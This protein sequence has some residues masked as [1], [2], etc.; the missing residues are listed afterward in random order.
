MQEVN[1]QRDIELRENP[2][3]PTENERRSFHNVDRENDHEY[4]R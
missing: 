1:M 3:G 4:K 2:N